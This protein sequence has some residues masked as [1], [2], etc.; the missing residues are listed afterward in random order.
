MT[1]TNGYLT[2]EEAL[3]FTGR[4]EMASSTDDDLDEAV[5]AAS[6]MVDTYCG[7]SFYSTASGVA[8][9]FD[10]CD[11]T[12]VDFGGYGDLITATLVEVDT[13]ASGSYS[14]FTAYQLAPV[15][16]VNRSWPYQGLLATGGATLPTVTA[17]SRRGL[18]RVTGT[19][20][21]SAVPV[22]VKQATRYILNE[23]VKLR[24]APLGVA[25]GS[26]MG[27]AFTRNDIP[28]R[29]RS[30]LAPYRHVSVFGLA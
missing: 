20:G 11:G 2:R 27:V 29:A 4:N 24:D 6:R 15:E 10:S 8:R 7:R 12:G 28:A 18:V 30:L 16:A 19:W 5:M 17:T 9:V 3:R 14:A 25:G 26:D 1:I 13:A 21:W 22:D 23:M